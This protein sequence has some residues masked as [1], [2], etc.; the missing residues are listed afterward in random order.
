MS[1]YRPIAMLAFILVSIPIWGSHSLAQQRGTGNAAHSIPDFRSNSKG[2]LSY[3]EVGPASR[4]SRRQAK[5][6]AKSACEEER[7]KAGADAWEEAQDFLRACISSGGTPICTSTDSGSGCDN[8]DCEQ[9]ANSYPTESW[10]CPPSGSEPLVD[11]VV[12]CV[13]AY[14]N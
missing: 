1:S 13:C 3:I 2:L 7:D 4:T 5:R 14:N 11:I 8:I 10:I 12:R 9:G 6:H